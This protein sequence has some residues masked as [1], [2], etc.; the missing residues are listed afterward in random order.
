M[1]VMADTAEKCFH[2]ALILIDSI[3]EL[4][5][6]YDINSLDITDPNPIVRIFVLKIIG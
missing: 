4:G 1:Y 2:N 3:R 5:L 6:D